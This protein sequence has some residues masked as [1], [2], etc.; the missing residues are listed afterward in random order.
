MGGRRT[1]RGTTPRQRMRGRCTFVGVVLLSGVASMAACSPSV[2]NLAVDAASREWQCPESQ[3]TIVSETVLP[4][5]PGS[6]R[7][8]VVTACGTT[9][10]IRCDNRSWGVN[11]VT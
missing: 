7:E 1:L 3:I 2:S 5:D 11:D 9:G 8:Y 6:H 4:S 10:T